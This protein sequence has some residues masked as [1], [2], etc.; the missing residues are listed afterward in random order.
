MFSIETAIALS[1]EDWKSGLRDYET[2]GKVSMDVMSF[3]LLGMSWASVTS[4]SKA[5]MEAI[6]GEAKVLVH[7]QIRQR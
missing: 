6:P 2:A 7:G 4:T 1:P 5:P 3:P